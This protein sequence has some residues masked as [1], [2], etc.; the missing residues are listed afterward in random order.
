MGD[1][2]EITVSENYPKNAKYP[3]RNDL[4]TVFA[5]YGINDICNVKL[6]DTTRGDADIRLNYIADKKYVLRFCNT[7]DLTED[8]LNGLQKLINRYLI[9]GIVCPRYISRSDGLYLHEWNGLMYYLSEYID[10][11]LADEVDIA[12]ED[13]L[14]SEILES[15][16][17][18]AE[19]N[20]NIDLLDTMGMYSLFDL[21]PFDKKE[22]I[23]EKEQNF[24]LLTDALN[25]SECTE[26]AEKLVCRHRS[27][28]K[29]LKEIYKDLPRCV[30]QCDENWS[31]ILIDAE[32]HFKGFID[33]NLAGTEVI[34]NQLA[35]LAGFDYDESNL[36]PI[37]A[38]RRFDNALRGYHSRM[39]TIRKIY[40]MNDLEQK[41]LCLYAWIVMISQW[42]AVCY[43]KKQL[44]DPIMKEEIVGLLNLIAELPESEL[45]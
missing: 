3:D 2:F 45:A 38:S 31:N 20:K 34:V 13:R 29:D 43:F 14:S 18:F 1:S 22:G 23:D 19:A 11:P 12:D 35:N 15:I 5:S 27:I 40:K 37:G 36:T 28:R 16:A 30:F 25:E 26:L 39:E 9:S 17:A 32:Q 21:C 44:N 4:L 8:R 33:F 24:N 6:I 7:P 42:P 10:L 41:A